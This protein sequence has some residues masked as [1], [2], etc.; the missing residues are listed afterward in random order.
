M[1]GAHLTSREAQELSDQLDRA[2]AGIPLA[3]GVV[4]WAAERAAPM[5]LRIDAW[6]WRSYQQIEA[7]RRDRRRWRRHDRGRGEPA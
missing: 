2:R 4:E 7:S 5:G 6:L 3:R 1:A